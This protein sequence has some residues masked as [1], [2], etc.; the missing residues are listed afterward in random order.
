MTRPFLQAR[1]LVP[2]VAL[3]ALLPLAACGGAESQLRK[4][5]VSAG[6]TEPMARCMAKPM[7]RQLSVDQLMKLRSLSK[8]SGLDPR[9]TTY[10]KVTRHLR[11]LEDP[12]ILRIT[13][14]AAVD[15]AIAL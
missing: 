6:L 13:T 5:L 3:C 1:C 2:L 15:C 10:E 11:A 8:V 9:R 12:E 7:A 4:G 14:S